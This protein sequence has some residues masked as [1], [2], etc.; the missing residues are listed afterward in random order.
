MDYTKVMNESDD[1]LEKLLYIFVCDSK[2]V[3][4]DVLDKVYVGNKL[5]EGVIVKMA[6]IARD[7]DEYLYYNKEE[8]DRLV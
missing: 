6:K 2:D 4:D 1:S 7:I 3:L 8:F 5:M